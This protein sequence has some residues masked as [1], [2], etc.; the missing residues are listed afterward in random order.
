MRRYL[1]LLLIA[2]GLFFSTTVFFVTSFITDADIISNT[3]E[4]GEIKVLGL[5]YYGVDDNHAN[6]TLASYVEMGNYGTKTGVYDVNISLNSSPRYIE[7]LRIYINV[8]SN[9]YTYVRVRI[10]EQKTIKY[11]RTIDVGGVPTTVTTEISKLME[12]PTLLNYRD[13]TAYWFDNRVTDENPNGD[14]YFYYMQK[15]IR[16]SSNTPFT[17]GL[18]T[19]YFSGQYY[20]SEPSNYSLQIGIVVEAIQADEYVAR[21]WGMETPPWGGTW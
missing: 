1:V 8:Y 10:I 18:I 12:T 21:N 19:S 17:W 5:A 3:V 14:G 7:K 16:T 13:E 6:D 11:T 20:S 15:A 9:V 4:V 2:I